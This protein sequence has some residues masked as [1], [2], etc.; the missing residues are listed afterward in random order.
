MGPT[1]YSLQDNDCNSFYR[2]AELAGLPGARGTCSETEVPAWPACGV[3][4]T[5]REMILE[6]GLQ[7]VELAN[8]RDGL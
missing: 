7:P 3:P 1:P 8:L 6:N 2:A 5:G 4:G